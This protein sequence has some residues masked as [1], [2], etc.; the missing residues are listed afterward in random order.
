LRL[1]NLRLT[2]KNKQNCYNVVKV[3]LTF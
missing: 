2:V 1:K 3:Y